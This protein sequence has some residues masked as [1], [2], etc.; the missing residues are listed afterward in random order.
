MYKFHDMRVPLSSLV[1][2][3]VCLLSAGWFSGSKG[4]G[5]LCTS[6]TKPSHPI[7]SYQANKSYIQNLGGLSQG[8]KFDPDQLRLDAPL[9]TS[10]HPCPYTS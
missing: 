10:F 9:R 8:F 1:H 6:L 2:G 3:T 7:L 4:F 5:W